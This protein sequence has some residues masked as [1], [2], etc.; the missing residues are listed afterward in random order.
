MGVARTH[1]LG[2]SRVFVPVEAL[3]EGAGFGTGFPQTRTLAG[4]A[5]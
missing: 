3:M 1:P 2:A 5:R 4:S